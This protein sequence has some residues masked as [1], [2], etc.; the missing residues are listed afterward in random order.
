ME[1]TKEELKGEPD[2]VIDQVLKR[3]HE[4]LVTRWEEREQKLQQLRQEEK[5]QE[6]R[7]VKRR[8]IDDGPKASAQSDEDAEWLLDDPPSEGP[9]SKDPF[10]G[11]SATTREI[12]GIG[13]SKSDADEDDGNLEQEIK[14]RLTPHQSWM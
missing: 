13:P 8:R 9:S 7:G 4:E 11:L 14:V 2:W 12:L 5:A 3:R 10:S 1:T 6:S